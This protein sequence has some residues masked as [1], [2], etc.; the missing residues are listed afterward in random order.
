MSCIL[1]FYVISTLSTHT[2]TNAI[3][4]RPYLFLI[5]FR[6]SCSCYS[7]Q[8]LDFDVLRFRLA[9]S[10]Y[11]CF[12]TKQFKKHFTLKP[13]ENTMY[14]CVCVSCCFKETK[15]KWQQ[16]DDMKIPQTV[17]VVIFK[18][19]IEST[20]MMHIFTL[21]DTQRFIIVFYILQRR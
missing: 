11:V 15:K 1:V 14:L 4:R 17:F 7:V 10:V 19:L 9:N 16:H 2:Y 18:D 12:P 8:L 3:K 6:I 13:N 5:D 21:H 20:M